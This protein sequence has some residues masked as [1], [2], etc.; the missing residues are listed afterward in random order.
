[1]AT[2][3]K[4]VIEIYQSVVVKLNMIEWMAARMMECKLDRRGA[5]VF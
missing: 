5:L 3:V 2:T 1:M 4:V